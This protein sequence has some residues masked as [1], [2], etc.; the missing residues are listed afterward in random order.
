M[1]KNTQIRSVSLSNELCN[2]LDDNEDLSLSKVAQE[3]LLRAKKE[4]AEIENSVKALRIRNERIAANFNK[5][6]SFVE[7]NGLSEKM[8]KARLFG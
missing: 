7:E 8:L 3:G 1:T 4:R 6:V 2:Y 5:L